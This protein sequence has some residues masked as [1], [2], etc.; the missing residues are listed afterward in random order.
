MFCAWPTLC[1]TTLAFLPSS[2][3]ESATEPAAFVLSGCEIACVAQPAQQRCGCQQADKVLD[4]WCKCR[5]AAAD[6]QRIPFDREMRI[7]V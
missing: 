2:V 3:L 4:L 7:R 5:H 6:G 1:F